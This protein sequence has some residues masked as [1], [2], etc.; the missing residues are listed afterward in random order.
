MSRSILHKSTSNHFPWRMR[1]RFK[2]FPCNPFKYV[3]DIRLRLFR[4][5]SKLVH[6]EIN[7]KTWRRNWYVGYDYYILVSW[8]N[9]WL[10]CWSHTDP[11]KK[12]IVL[13]RTLS[14]P[15][16]NTTANKNKAT[17]K[18]H[19]T[20]MRKERSI[21]G[22]GLIVSMNNSLCTWLKYFKNQIKQR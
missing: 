2:G 9:N 8:H 10:N 6:V 16:I 20:T 13:E 22:Y 5:F 3:S 17:P 4:S 12:Y 1:I 21:P 19:R 18:W 14:T 11:K 15:T 7:L